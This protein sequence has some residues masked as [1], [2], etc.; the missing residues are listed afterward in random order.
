MAK[1]NQKSNA[2]VK[3]DKNVV[4]DTAV[5]SEGEAE[6][7]EETTIE[8]V[9]VN[10]KKTAKKEKKQKP[11]KTKINREPKK[12]KFKEVFA[13]LK[14]VNWPSFGK[15]MKQTGMVLSIVLIFGVVVLGF[16]TLISWLLGLL[17][18]I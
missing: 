10:D 4:E 6:V 2:K 5:I 11:A 12:S 15:T 1:N 7:V 3:D 9:S 8:E 18:K 16:D 14:K 13:E 17:T